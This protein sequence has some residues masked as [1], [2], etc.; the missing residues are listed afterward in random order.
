MSQKSI[1]Y[2]EFILDG[3]VQASKPLGYLQNKALEN[4]NL[5]SA[6]KI[7]QLEFKRMPVFFQESVM[8]PESMIINFNP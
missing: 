8:S 5:V 4:K 7:N 1:K 2:S 3:A 6:L